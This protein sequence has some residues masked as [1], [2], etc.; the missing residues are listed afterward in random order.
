MSVNKWTKEVVQ[1]KLRQSLPAGKAFAPLRLSALDWSYREAAAVL[2]YFDP[3]TLQPADTTLDGDWTAIRRLLSDSNRVMDEGNRPGWMLRNSVRKNALA[4]L[5]IRE[6][7]K[8]ALQINRPESPDPLQ[9]TLERYIVGKTK[10]LGAQNLDELTRTLQVADWLGG[11]LEGV[12]KVEDVKRRIA[13]ERLLEPF[14]YLVGDHFRGRKEELRRLRDYVEVLPPD[15]A[16]EVIGRGLRSIFSL[17]EKPPMLIYGLGGIGKST[18]LA[19]FILEHMQMHQQARFPFTYIDFD[20]PEILAEEPLTILNEALRQLGIQ[21][22][23]ISRQSRDLRDQ[24]ARHIA[25][26]ATPQGKGQYFS[27]ALGSDTGHVTDRTSFLEDFAKIME[28]IGEVDKPYLLV[29]DTFEEV[30]YRSRDLVAELWEFLDEMQHI[31][32]RLR[33]VL[34]GRAPIDN[35]TTKELVLK[36]FD[37][38]SGIGFLEAHGV[39]DPQLTLGETFDLFQRAMAS[40]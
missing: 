7:M 25:Q 29:L 15:S 13:W 11:I 6:R 40:R 39:T 35:F 10:R 20:R 3:T 2:T 36:E 37:T 30:Q 22:T 33:T 17:H 8:K 27:S 28:A 26:E 19:K 32:P 14:R 16:K 5:G 23:E 34:A 1:Q 18:L 21:Y 24:W 31:L 9:Q 12:P 38:E 4:R